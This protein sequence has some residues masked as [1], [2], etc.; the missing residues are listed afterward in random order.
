[1][2]THQ[3]AACSG[4][5]AFL[6]SGSQ[7]LDNTSFTRMLRPW[8]VVQV[9]SRS[10]VFATSQFQAGSSTDYHTV[11]ELSSTSGTRL[12]NFGSS[13]TGDGEFNNPQGI[14][15]DSTDNIYVVDNGNSRIQKFNGGGAFQLKWGSAGTCDGELSNPHGL[16]VNSTDQIYVVDSDNSRIQQ[17]DATGGYLAKFGTS[18][19]GNSQFDSPRD[20]AFDSSGNIYVTDTDNF[21]VQKFNSAHTFQLAFGTTTTG[22]GGF[23]TLGPYGVAV[24]PSDRIYVFTPNN[25][26]QRF[27]ATGGFIDE[28]GTTEISPQSNGLHIDSSGNVYMAQTNAATVARSNSTGTLDWRFRST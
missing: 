21:R 27:N 19:T 20:I 18:G 8:D 23:G 11:V 28:W 7:A 3:A 9:D 16:E 15:T 14:D 13:G 12:S 2:P 26:L 10:S 1:M 5:Q 6:N 25:R 4:F 24:D 22:N 17:F